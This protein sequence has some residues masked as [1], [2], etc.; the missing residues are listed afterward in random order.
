M[1][2]EITTHLNI[3]FKD[4]KYILINAKQYDR[5]SRNLLITCYNHGKVL[6]INANEHSAYVRYKKSN[7]NSVFNL[8]EIN[9]NGK[10]CIE[11]TEQ[12]LAS[13]GICCADLVIVDKGRASVDSETGEII[14][15]NGSSILS[16]MTFYIDVSE[17]AV[18][19]SEIESSYEYSGLNT[20]LGKAE[21]DYKEV[22]LA[23]KSWAVGGTGTRENEDRD[24]AKYYYESALDSA[25]NAESSENKAWNSEQNAKASE[26]NAKTSEVKAKQSETNASIS[27]QN[28]KNSEAEAKQSE[29]N[30]LDS[31][32]RAKQS[33]INAS[34]S[35]Q[36]SKISENNASVSEQNAK[37]SELVL[38]TSANISQSYAVGGTGTRENEDTDN[39]HY[40]YEMVKSVANGLNSGFIPIGTI[41][42]SEL[43]TAEKATGFTYNISDDF[44][45]DDTFMEGSGKSYTAGT[46]VYFTASGLWDAF[47]GS[48]SPTATVGE[49][50]SYLGI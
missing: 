27:E 35:E 1:S 39:A 25:N 18:V 22:I 9:D 38:E 14:A 34:I 37:N 30:T 41:S 42:F 50:K 3:D 10:I 29:T 44:V 4:N 49:V 7:E 17:T 32:A 2:L 47:G 15:I 8:C 23:S 11:L 21:A 48:A 33:E 45:T 43:A 24:N 13:E 16:T 31:E 46:N 19:N 20:L 12:M 40:Y 28:S 26:Q 6:P 36:N 5:K